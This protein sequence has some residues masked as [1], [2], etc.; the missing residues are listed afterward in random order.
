MSPKPQGQSALAAALVFIVLLVA[1]LFYAKWDP[2]FHKAFAAA[3][4]HTLGASI[5]SGTSASPPAPSLAAAWDYFVTYFKDIWIALI[6]GLVLGSGVQ[7]L[8]PRD[9]LL[10][11]FGAAGSRSAVLAGVLAV[12]SMMCTCCS[13]PMVVGMRR[14]KV[15]NGAALAYWLGNPVLNPATIL[16]VGFVLGWNWAVLRIT[17]GIV[18]V[19]G[20]AWL[21]NREDRLAGEGTAQALLDAL[22]EEEKAPP[23]RFGAWLSALWR[24]CIGLIPEYVVV[25]ALLG[26]ARAWLF[27]AISPAI[28][29]SILLLVGLA[30]AGTLF[31]IPTAGEVPVIQTLMS[32]GLG[33]GSAGALLMTLP[34]VS[35]PSLV[36]VGRAVSVRLLVRVTALVFIAGIVAGLLALA[37]G[38]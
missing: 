23:N 7:A 10:R 9:W 35:L 34:A 15:S 24:L 5:I 18:L 33:T 36:M 31:V 38:L 37:F 1:G 28:G 22:P 14:A 4:S 25:V 21:G 27:P 17:V 3:A 6:V 30:A 13:A 20:A 32:Y 8:L 2:Y 12:P 16:F 29:G 19:A 26:L 11:L